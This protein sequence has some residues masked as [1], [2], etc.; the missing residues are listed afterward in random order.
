V[1]RSERPADERHP[2]GYGAE[3]FFWSLIAAVGSSWPEEGS[4]FSRPTSPF[5]RREV[6]GIGRKIIIG[7]DDQ[8]IA[9]ADHERA[10]LVD[11]LPRYG[12]RH[13]TG[14]VTIPDDCLTATVRY[15]SRTP[16]TGI[17]EKRS[18]EPSN[19][20]DRFRCS[21]QLLVRQIHAHNGFVWRLAHVDGGSARE[22]ESGIE[23]LT[24]ALRVRCS[25]G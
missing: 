14:A 13:P 23:P 6:V 20:P 16:L 18:F 7:E 12:R 25:T 17:S 1:R 2:F 21:G 10:P 24:Y 5:T 11:L 4:P 9:V 22:P 15:T 19:P 8:P 3:R